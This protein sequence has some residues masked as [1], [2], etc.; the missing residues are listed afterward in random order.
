MKQLLLF[1]MALLVFNAC[2]TT[3][4]VAMNEYTPSV[5]AKDPAIGVIT[6]ELI[7]DIQKRRAAYIQ[8]HS[9]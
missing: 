4:G 5:T 9:K 7:K 8:T 3:K 2:S 1:T 6:P